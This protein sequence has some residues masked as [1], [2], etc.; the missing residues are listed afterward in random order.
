[1][2]SVSREASVALPMRSVS[3]TA[4]A[5][6]HRLAI[7]IDLWGTDELARPVASAAGSAGSFGGDAA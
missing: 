3:V 5:A 6:G 4:V 7:R 1:M 2:R